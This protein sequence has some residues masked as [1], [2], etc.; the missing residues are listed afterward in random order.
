MKVPFKT[1]GVLPCVTVEE[2]SGQ[3]TCR[4]VNL[5]FIFLLTWMVSESVL[6]SGML[7]RAVCDDNGEFSMFR[8][9][10]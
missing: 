3:T 9:M 7:M 1:E 6:H 2:V 5:S 10:M 8:M 4:K